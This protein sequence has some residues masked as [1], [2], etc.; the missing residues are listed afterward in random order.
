[1]PLILY[2]YIA[3]EIIWPF[4]LGLVTF[5]SVLLMGRMLKIADLVVSK[6][7]PVKEVLLLIIYLLPYFLMVTIPMSLLLAI[8]LAFSRL[9]ADSEI[10][11]MKAGGISLFKLLPPVMLI[12]IITYIFTTI[13]SVYALPMGDVAFKN[14]LHNVIQNRL[15]MEVKEQVFNDIIPGVIIYVDHY[16]NKTRELSG[17]LIQDERNPNSI[18]TIFA[19]K[20]QLTA[21]NETKEVNLSLSNGSIHQL[22]PNGAYQILGFQQYDLNVDLKKAMKS[23]EKNELDMSMSELRSNLKT[24]GFSKK[25][26]IDMGL[27]VYRR[28]AIPFVCF[29]FAIIAMPLGIHNQRSGKAAG[30]S[31]SIFVILVYYI[32]QTLFY[33]FGEREIIHPALAIWAPN[34]IFMIVGC[35]LFYLATAEKKIPM[36]GTIL[37]M[38]K[39]IPT[40]FKKQKS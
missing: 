38:F 19:D 17:I 33:S 6:G 31:L 27:E 10:T 18:S 7:V 25:L 35:Y 39:K 9:S 3:K 8:L 24:G 16:N 29:I 23:F 34:I 40:V 11:V 20:G 21:S 1:M 32:V 37:G 26:T 2:R 12:A 5:T 13:I 30:F 36:L 22:K 4:I 28:I 15:T 14:L